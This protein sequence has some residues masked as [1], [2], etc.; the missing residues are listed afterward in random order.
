[1]KISL[2]WLGDYL[3]WKEKDPAAIARVITAHVAEVD[4]VEMQGELLEGCCVGK[5]LSVEKHPNADKLSLCDVQTDQGKKRVVCGGTNLRVGMRVAFA[6]IGTKVRWHGTEMVTLEKAKIRGEMSEGMICAAEELDLADQYPATPEQGERAI[7]DFGDGDTGVGKPLREFLGMDGAVLHIDNHAITHRPDLF[8]HI[9]FAREL[10]A[11]GLAKWKKDPSFAAPKFGKDS[12]PFKFVISEPKLMP[13]YCACL[14][15]I[16]SLGETPDWMR[17]RLQATGWRSINLPIDITNYVMMETGL[18]MHSFDEADIHGTVHMRK[19][20]AGESITTLDKKQFKLPEGALVLNDDEGIF[21]LLGIMGGLRSSTKATTRRIYLHG[22]SLDPMSIRRAVI[23]TGQR[24]DAATV[25]EKGVPFVTTEEGFHRA[26]QLFLDLVPGAKVVSKKESVGDNG[27][28][29]AIKFDIEHA[30]I[31][32]G[33]DIPAADIAR[34]LED[35]GCTV[36]KGTG[37][38][39]W[40]VT[41]PL[42]RSDLKAQ[43][44]LMEEVGRIYGYDNIASQM[45]DANITPPRRDHRRNHLRDGLK[46]GG[47]I[48]LVPLSLLGPDLLQR[49]GLDPSKAIKVQNALGE[50][51]SLLQPTLLPALLEHAQE[52]MLHVE[53]SLKTF[54]IARVFHADGEHTELAIL[55]APRRNSGMK[56]EAFL[57]AKSALTAA[58]LPVGYVPD[59]TAATSVPAFAHPGRSAII[60]IADTAVGSIFELHPSVSASFDLPHR[61]AVVLINLDAVFAMEPRTTLSPRISAFPSIVYDI[62]VKLNAQKSAEEL[63]EEMYEQTPLLRTVEFADLYAAAPTAKEYTVTFRLTYQSDERTLTEAEVK[64]EH[65]KVLAVLS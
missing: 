61:S 24:T 48:E 18:P 59:F 32:L 60:H 13:R 12:L 19:A 14:L 31:S 58:L 17:K 27:K 47:L 9:G 57:Q 16:D 46:E 56:D 23:A 43:H 39:A 33:A 4:D 1:M 26:V 63:R 3:Q 7:V 62:T 28:S 11:L 8:S 5:I 25:Y 21:D 50:E 40:S 10:V 6:H 49:C 44:D 29:A 41:L 30:R 35:L 15:E 54:S 51:L 2:E 36:K 45:P 34:I 20:K 22:A 38:A 37:K 42:W 55:V 53:N 64:A 65:E 52:N